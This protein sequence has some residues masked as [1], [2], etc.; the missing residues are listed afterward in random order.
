M[1]ATSASMGAN[2]WISFPTDGGKDLIIQWGAANCAGA[3]PDNGI[4]N[5]FPIPFPSVAQRMV[6][7]HSGY[8]PASAGILS[9][10]IKNNSQFRA[11]SSVSTTGVSGFYIAIGY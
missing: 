4:L 7:A 11:F 2:G 6:I 5:T 9:F 3:G 10:M 8:S 1:P